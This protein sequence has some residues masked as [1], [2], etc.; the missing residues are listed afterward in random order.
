MTEKR[1]H[2]HYREVNLLLLR[3][4]IY[5]SHLQTNSNTEIIVNTLIEI[6]GID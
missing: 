5:G 4:I 1:K 3:F 2:Q 6:D